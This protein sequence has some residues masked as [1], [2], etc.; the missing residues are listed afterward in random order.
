MQVY[1]TTFFTTLPEARTWCVGVFAWVATGA[2]GAKA[3]N[4]KS[5]VTENTYILGT[6]SDE[7]FEYV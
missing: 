4:A 3:G 1:D 5:G 2:M 7:C 6:K